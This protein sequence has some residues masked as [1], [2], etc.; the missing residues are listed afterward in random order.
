MWLLLKGKLMQWVQSNGMETLQCLVE[1]L[2]SLA[3]RQLNWSCA[4]C[5]WLDTGLEMSAWYRD[6]CKTDDR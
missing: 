1:T 4:T 2:C 5:F 3:K 6:R